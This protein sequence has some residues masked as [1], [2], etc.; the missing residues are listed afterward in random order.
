VCRG[1]VEIRA[2]GSIYEVLFNVY[3]VSEG[4][5]THP[6]T[7]TGSQIITVRILPVV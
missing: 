7:V 2:I 3:F 1:N 4:Q 6:V 5:K